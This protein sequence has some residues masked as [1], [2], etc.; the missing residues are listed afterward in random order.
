MNVLTGDYTLQP[1]ENIIVGDVTLFSCQTID[2]EVVD[3]GNPAWAVLYCTNKLDD[4]SKT[5]WID[6]ATFEGT[7]VAIVQHSWRYLRCEGNMP[8]HISAR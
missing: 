4:P 7:D 1:A 5:E 6:M 2:T 3:D 8:I